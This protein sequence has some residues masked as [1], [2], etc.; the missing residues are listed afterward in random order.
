MKEHYLAPPVPRRGEANLHAQYVIIIRIGIRIGMCIYISTLRL[1]PACVCVCKLT[2]FPHRFISNLW[3]AVLNVTWV[4]KMLIIFGAAVWSVLNNMGWKVVF[5]FWKVKCV[6]LGF[7]RCI[8]IRWLVTSGDRPWTSPP[9]RRDSVPNRD[10][11][12][13][14][15]ERGQ[16]WLYWL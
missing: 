14:V 15:R 7:Y 4:N 8:S 5:G 3:G 9:E 12:E 6:K 11:W 13:S 1:S 2:L 10:P 16:S